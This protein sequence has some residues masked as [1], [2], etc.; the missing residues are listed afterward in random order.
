MD[1]VCRAHVDEVLLSELGPA[2]GLRLS[3]E[4]RAQQHKDLRLNPYTYVAWRGSPPTAS[5]CA[6]C[7][8]CWHCEAAFLF[9][10]SNCYGALPLLRKRALS[11]VSAALSR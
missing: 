10:G 7:T 1:V 6:H 9:L 11:P 2:A 8:A 3:P 4:A 5:S